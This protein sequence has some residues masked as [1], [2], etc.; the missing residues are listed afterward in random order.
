MSHDQY[1]KGDLSLTINDVDYTKRT[2]YTC[3]CGGEHICDVSIQ[4]ETVNVHKHIHLGQSVSMD[5][6]VT[7]PVEMILNR[8]HDTKP[9]LVRLCAVD[10]REIQCVPEYEKRVSYRFSL[11]LE[12]LKESDSGVYTIWD[13]RNEE[14]IATYRVIVGVPPQAL[15]NPVTTVKLNENTTLPCNQTCSGLVTWTVFH[16]PDD[17]LA[18][19]NQTSCQSKEGFHM[20]HDQYLKENLSLTITDVDYT[21]RAWYTCKCSSK[22]LCDWNLEVHAFSFNVHV[23]PGESLTMDVP[24]S[25]PVEVLFNKSGDASPNPVSLCEVYGHKIQCVPEY[26]KRV[27]FSSSLQLKELKESDSGVYIIRDTRNDEVIATYMVTRVTA[28]GREQEPDTDTVEKEPETLR[29]SRLLLHL[30]LPLA[31]VL[32]LIL[33]AS[34]WLFR[35]EC[36]LWM[37][38]QPNEQQHEMQDLPHQVGEQRTNQNVSE[39][40]PDIQDLLLNPDSS[41]TESLPSHPV[42]DSSDNELL[43]DHVPD[44]SNNEVK[45]ACS[46][47]KESS[48]SDDS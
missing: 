37:N 1:L 9:N 25:E 29:M 18:Q 43:T 2:R 21:K 30:G 26:E 44:S 32:L 41:K 13:T 46:E 48:C 33:L 36:C 4:I 35:N 6:N 17:I 15:Q 28:G 12:D 19:C 42:L 47:I 3:D 8:T 24:V 10:G 27:S 38:V 14:V 23:L 39:R 16:K 5:V 31:V 34:Y 7:E 22:T 45:D 40:E 11:Q 20:S